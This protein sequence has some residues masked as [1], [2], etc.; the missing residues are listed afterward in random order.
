MKWVKTL[1]R[2][3]ILYRLAIV[4]PAMAT[5]SPSV[6]T[7]YSDLAFLGNYGIIACLHLNS[8]PLA[9]DSINPV[10]LSKSQTKK[11]NEYFTFLISFRDFHPSLRQLI[12]LATGK[13]FGI[14]LYTFWEDTIRNRGKTLSRHFHFSRTL[15]QKWAARDHRAAGL[16]SRIQ[17]M[18][19]FADVMIASDALMNDS[20]LV[21]EV[22]AVCIADELEHACDL[23]Y[24]GV[25][26]LWEQCLLEH[27]SFYR[28]LN[29]E[30]DSLEN[31][32]VR[33]IS[34]GDTETAEQVRKKKFSEKIVKIKY[35]G[36][37]KDFEQW[38]RLRARR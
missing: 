24:K 37:K 5:S 22:W 1:C 28:S 4:S 20:D 29:Q 13:S 8:P 3:L 17:G 15:E 25:D 34:I 2:L 18:D 6:H 30:N 32:A 31:E 19:H 27:Y 36:F 35:E 7:G 21:P 16:T 9:G 11:F 12:R 38:Q 10:N 26:I 33:L 23:T 14:D